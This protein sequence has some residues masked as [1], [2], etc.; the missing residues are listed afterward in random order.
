MAKANLFR[1]QGNGNFRKG[2]GFV[3]PLLIWSVMQ[4]ARSAQ[5]FG[6]GSE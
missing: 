5:A 6:L 4:A 3:K 2:I 1:Q